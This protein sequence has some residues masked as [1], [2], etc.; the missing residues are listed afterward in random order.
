MRKDQRR[1][2]LLASGAL[3]A[4]PL[5]RAQAPGNIRR[6][7]W[8]SL[9]TANDLDNAYFGAF[10]ARLKDL[11]YVEGRDVLIERRFADR[12]VER[13]PTLARELVALKPAV[14]V[15]RPSYAVAAAMQATRSVP[16]V[17]LGVGAPV[18]AGLVASLGRPGG[19]VTGTT[20]NP[21]EVAGKLVE[22]LK[23][24]A[25]R[26][27]RITIIWNPDAPGLQAFKPYADRAA[28]ALG[29][30][31]HYA[32]IRRPEDFVIDMVARGRPEALYV[33]TDI[34]VMAHMVAINRFALQRKLP[35][36]G[37]A[38]QFVEA[39]GL[40]YYGPD[41]SAMYE[42]TASFVDRILRGAKPGDLPVELPTK[43]ELVINKNTAQAIG[44][45]PS[46]SFMLRVD[47][48]V[49]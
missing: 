49:E 15:A 22:V 47:R 29:I 4:A 10:T 13:L 43:Y 24:A 18:E 8:L 11:G 23:A 38:K 46:K 6:I 26:T 41:F 5:A 39:G 25:P 44:F 42:R 20:F 14:I 12:V 45:E 40:I 36:I 28:Q 21:P 34:A 32:D 35:S 31:L 27:S 17:M 37:T 1:R 33:V 16:I 2:F 3:L 48:Q 7:G 30:D 19:N 9:G